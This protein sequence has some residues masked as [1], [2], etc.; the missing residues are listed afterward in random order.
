MPVLARSLIVAALVLGLCELGSAAPQ[1]RKPARR[2]P[3]AGERADD[4]PPLCPITFARNPQPQRPPARSMPEMFERMADSFMR[5]PATGFQD[6][7]AELGRMDGPGLEG[8]TLSPAEE[9]QAGKQARDEYLRQAAAKSYRVVND[10]EKLKYLRELVEGLA[11]HMTHRARYPILDI[12]LID[13]PLADGRSF[14]GGCLV[15]TT[16]LLD[17]PDEA[18]V[19]GVVAHELAH[20]D[21]GHLYEYARRGKLA[22]STSNRPP[23]MGADFDQFFTRQMALFGMLMNPFRPEHEHAAD[24]AATTWLYLDGYDPKGLVAFFERMH[25]QQ[26]DQPDNPF[27]NFGRS[28]P[29]TL[30]RRAH[31]MRRLLQLQDWRRRN[32]LGLFA[33][34]LRTR[35]SRYRVQAEANANRAENDR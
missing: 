18:T 19:A 2:A 11:K 10:P 7:V 26:Q 31:V 32:D 27:F 5:S 29:F 14:P 13:A 22:E 1:K 17:E 20:L 6:W 15:F 21:L 23:G 30:D 25:G 9:R 16:A 3:A 28:H 12:T 4:A 24:C 33:E 34:N 8:V 35:K